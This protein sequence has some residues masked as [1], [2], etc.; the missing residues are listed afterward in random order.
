MTTQDTATEL[1]I[2]KSQQVADLL[3]TLR[4][5]YWLAA[6]AKRSHVANIIGSRAIDAINKHAA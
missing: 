5:I 1:L 3:N 2:E 6:E 4:E